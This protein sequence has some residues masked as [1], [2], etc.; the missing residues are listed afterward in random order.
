MPLEIEDAG[1]PP[2]TET[3][4]FAGTDYQNLLGGSVNFANAGFDF[5]VKGAPKVG[6][7][8]S[9]DYNTGGFEDNRNGLMLGNLQNADMVRINAATTVNADKYQTFN[10]AYSELVGTVGT[11]TSQARVAAASSKSLLEQTSA[12]HESLSGVSLD[13]EAA[14]LVRFQQTYAAAAKIL[15]TSQ[16][17]F[18]TL[19][20]ASR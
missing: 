14:D 4:T 11:Q 18:D 3:I 12:W 9:I 6:D 16:T 1:A 10:Q 19:L 5:S 8:F 20:Q 2:V 17:I 7:T 15:S 13:E